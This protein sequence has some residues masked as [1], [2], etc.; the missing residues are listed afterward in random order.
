[1]N[2]GGEDGDAKVGGELDGVGPGLGGERG[3]SRTRALKEARVR[4]ARRTSEP[5]TCPVCGRA[6]SR[7]TTLGHG[8]GGT[9]TLGAI[10][11]SSSATCGPDDP[12]L[13]G[14]GGGL[15]AVGLQAPGLGRER[16]AAMGVG[17]RARVRPQEW[18][19]PAPAAT[20]T[21]TASSSPSSSISAVSTSHPAPP[22]RDPPRPLV[23]PSS[24]SDAQQP[25]QPRH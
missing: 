16:P 15:T 18:S 6:M 5:L 4:V 25:C 9:W 10:R 17:L 8:S 19:R 13:G 11:R 21:T 7:A 23:P 14:E 20:A 1:M 2:R 22:V 3:S 24:T 12:R